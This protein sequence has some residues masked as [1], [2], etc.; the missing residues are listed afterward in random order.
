[1]KSIALCTITVLLSANEALAQILAPNGNKP[2]VKPEDTE[3]YEPVP[4]VVQA[5][6]T[7]DLPSSDAVILFDG[8][9]LDEWESSRDKSAAKWKVEEGVF[10]VDK[11]SG[12]IQTKK[13]FTN[14][15]LH[16][17]YRI[18]SIITGSGQ[19]RGNSGIFLAATK[20]NAGGY[21]IQVLDGYNNENKTYV[22]GMVGS[23][24]KQSIPLVNPA[25]KAGEWN[26]YDIIWTAPTFNS[27]STVKTK[28]RITAF[29]NGVLVQN[30]FEIQGETAYIGKHAYVQ[31]GAAPIKLQAHGDR[32][33]PIS[34]RNIW[35]REL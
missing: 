33:E 31:H 21:E 4:K 11:R 12:D 2:P 10:T 22:N 25:R 9:N 6:K 23:I 29:L 35:L 7:F 18:P 15:Q 32:S 19:A 1:M 8:K 34:Y 27:D 14:F 13:T 30:N 16:I 17:E 3:V 5:G 26:V 20:G 28:A 24:Y